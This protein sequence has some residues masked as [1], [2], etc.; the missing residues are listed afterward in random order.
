VAALACTCGVTRGQVPEPPPQAGNPDQPFG[1]WLRGAGI[2]YWS[3][4]A[5]AKS[6]RP[7]LSLQAEFAVLGPAPES[8]WIT[9]TFSRDADAFCAA[10]KTEPGTTYYGIGVT[11]EP[12][13]LAARRYSGDGVLP[14]VIG[15]LPDGRTFGAW[16]DTTAPVEIDLT[17]GVMFRAGENFP[18]H[19][20]TADSPAGVAG[21]LAIMTGWFELPPQWSLG[22][23][24]A[25]PGL[26]NEA[27]IMT[28]AK[29]FRDRGIPCDTLW[30]G[31][32]GLTVDG[33]AF[34]DL[35]R[36]CSELGVQG[37][38]AMW[39]VP[40]LTDPAGAGSTP[41]ETWVALLNGTTL[42]VSDPP[43]VLPDFT[44]E[45]TRRW[46]AE[47][48]APLLQSGISGIGLEGE[49]PTFPRDARF[50]AD[51]SL[52]GPDGPSRYASVFATLAGRATREAFKAG[53]PDSRAFITGS[54]VSIGG[55][56]HAG[57]WIDA[58]GMDDPA[59]ERSL[60]RIEAAAGS[61]RFLV[62]MDVPGAPAGSD[63]AALV[64]WMGAAALMPMIRGLPGPGA[65]CDP[66]AFG[67]AVE[68][69]VRAALERR[70]RLMPFLYTAVFEAFRFDEPVVR[71]LAFEA[72]TDPALR[73]DPW[74]F[75]LGG[76]VLVDV[77]PGRT[78][79]ERNPG[80]PGTWRR[81]ET[82]APDPALPAMFLRGGAILPLGPVSRCVDDV[83]LDPLELVVS[84]DEAGTAQGVL[85]EDDREGFRYAKNE[86]RIAYYTA[87]RREGEVVVKM[88]R[89]DGGWHIAKRKLVVRVL[90]DDGSEA[91]AEFRD[92]L[93]TRVKLP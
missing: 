72:P 71:P 45:A 15:V 55:Q 22:Y 49:A 38:R 31:S 54:A 79:Q 11:A 87:E 75:I 47:A 62:G 67:P 42:R 20:A 61:A 35:G 89:L 81:F 26:V 43:R 50:A 52:G 65:T 82:G 34:P 53:R 59:L 2:R 77:R 93:E 58:Q 41:S 44:R 84:L 74:R 78:P 7:S 36:L 1:E 39:S 63:G 21:A 60:R 33:S 28:A 80:I 86:G 76:R 14:W 56:R 88:L 40:V 8:A 25:D 9:P 46:W 69:T 70:S 91:T 37:F 66:W 90:L 3:S 51:E 17:N 16:A 92:G 10:I 32:P 12:R 30:I 48:L 57:L 83:P 23:Q 4:E 6:A 24:H 19:V 85:Y 29:G 73:G 13:P 68:G 18:V 64:R 27:A 5:A